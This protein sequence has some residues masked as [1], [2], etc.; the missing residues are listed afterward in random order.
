MCETA[1]SDEAA[2]HVGHMVFLNLI[3]SVYPKLPPG[4]DGEEKREKTM[5]KGVDKIF[6]NILLE[7]TVTT[8]A[9]MTL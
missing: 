1:C 5:K 6:N 4:R 2:P 7:T 9:V 3:N 8:L